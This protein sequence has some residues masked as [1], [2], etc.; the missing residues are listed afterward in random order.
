MVT[1]IF[2]VTFEVNNLSS[3]SYKTTLDHWLEQVANRTILRS[4]MCVWTEADLA[5][6]DVIDHWKGLASYHLKALI[7]CVWLYTLKVTA[8]V[9]L[10]LKKGDRER[11]K[12]HYRLFL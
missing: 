10:I 3:P 8:E 9:V 1:Y 2:L 11:T 5:V 7:V 4:K 6:Q 12:V